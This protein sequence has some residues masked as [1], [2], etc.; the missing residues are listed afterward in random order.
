MRHGR[1]S[2]S[3]Q[4]NEMEKRCSEEALKER[5]GRR[6]D[7]NAR[8]KDVVGALVECKGRRVSVAGR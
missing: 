6:W 4:K 8:L 1:Y 2:S 5:G 7:W 3:G